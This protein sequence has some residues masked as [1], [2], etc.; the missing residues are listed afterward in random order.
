MRP[1]YCRRG[2]GGKALHER[3]VLNTHLPNV[4]AGL[5]A[6]AM[7][8]STLMLNV[9]AISRASPLPQL[10]GGVLDYWPNFTLVQPRVMIR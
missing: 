4:G 1:F 10:I 2:S 7:C 3:K 9:M 5:L 6:N 8:Q